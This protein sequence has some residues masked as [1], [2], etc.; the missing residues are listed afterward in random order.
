MAVHAANH[1]RAVLGELR[2][3]P[4]AKRVRAMLGG[5]TVADTTRALLV[6]EPQRVVP[7]YAVPEDDVLAELLLTQVAA[8]G[9][10]STDGEV[11]TVR[12][13]GGDRLGAGFR[14]ADPDLAGHI[15]LDFAA[16]DEW[17]EEEERIISHPRDPFTRIDVRRSTR[18]VRIERDGRVLAESTRPRLLFETHLPARFYLPREDVHTE[19]LRP[20]DTVTTCAYKGEAAYWS[21]DLDG[22][23]VQDIAW[24]YPQP[25]T[26]AVEVRDLLCFFDERVDV[27]VDGVPWERPQTPWS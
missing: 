27:I 6:W 24:S 17:F 12:A 26:D 16:F 7:Q 5:E 25:L 15:V 8:F 1:V 10:H 23:T 18:H 20:S 11:L 21:L 19:L 14:P 3:Q 13:T 4:T 9:V 22:H 2:Y